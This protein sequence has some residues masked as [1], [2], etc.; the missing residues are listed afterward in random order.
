MKL[1]FKTI[2]LKV[3]KPQLGALLLIIDKV[4]YKK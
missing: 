2:L 3:I 1:D 4:I